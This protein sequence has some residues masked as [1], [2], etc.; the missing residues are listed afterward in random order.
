MSP[1][2]PTELPA[3]ALLWQLRQDG[4]HTDCWTT[5]LPIGVTQAQ[6]VEAF[7][8]TPLFKAE[9]LV[10]RLLA[11]KPS[12][13]QGARDLAQG[14][15]DAFAAWRVAQRRPDQILL[16]DQTGR[17][18]SWLMVVPDRGPSAGTGTRL[19]FGS[20]VTGRRN[21]TTG[22]REFG[23]VFHALLGFHKLYS[24]LLL[25]A[26]AARLLAGKVQRP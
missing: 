11:R 26:A 2:V 4:S 20:A 3:T 21:H 17:T 12:T 9:R 15:C 7:Y 25:Q 5:Q 1:A 23:L 10:L 13:D 14:R 8:T 22:Q 19:F 16:T 6:Y 18:S 24:R